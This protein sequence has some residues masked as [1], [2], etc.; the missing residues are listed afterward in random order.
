MELK[1]TQLRHFVNVASSKSFKEAARR[2]F[3]SQPAISLAVKTLES[4]LGAQ[5]FEN[6]KR[7]VLTG[8]G[9]AVLP[10]FQEFLEHHDRL[11]RSIE[12]ASK[13]QSGDISIAANPSVASRWLP[14]IIREYTEKYPGV[15]LFATD[16]NSEKVLELVAS[17]RVDLGLASDVPATS[18]IDFTPIITDT[19]GV[20]CR[21]DHRLNKRAGALEWSQLRGVSIIG[22]MTHG[23]LASHQVHTYLQKPRMF[24]ST[25]TSLLA[26][27]E[28]GVGVTVLPKLAAPD[29]HP[30]LTFKSLRSPQLHRTIGILVRRGRT[31]P[32]HAQAMREL[33]LRR[34]QKS[35]AA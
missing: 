9:T 20:V 27:V 35:R 7:V 12:Q 13:G 28:G 5:L 11:A 10:I 14:L 30:I 34:F 23:L 32:P 3:R 6:G 33:I 19:F 1:A 2:S 22:N 8:L 21:R 31:L 25:L 29:E 17:G 24:M 18:E 16:D 4:Q 26:N 15:G